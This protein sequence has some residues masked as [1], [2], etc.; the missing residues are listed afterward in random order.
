MVDNLHRNHRRRMKERLRRQG[1]DSFAP[2]EQVELLLYY[3]IPRGDVNP[4]AHRLIDTFG[5]LA[6]ICQARWED[7]TAVQGV[8][9]HTA[10]FFQTLPQAARVYWES[11]ATPVDGY[12]TAQKIGTYL[13][14][15]Y[16]GITKETV[17]LL[18]FGGRM[19]L[20]GCETLC[21]GSLTAVT[22]NIRTILERAIVVGAARVVLAH[23][24]PD[25]LAIPS[26]DDLCITQNLAA[27]LELAGIPLVEHF[28]IAGDRWT[29]ILARENR[30]GRLAQLEHYDAKTFYGDP[31]APDIYTSR[32]SED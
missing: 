2:H 27:A 25:G 23:N 13:L 8:S 30:A 31:S 9:E 24:H 32:P 15:Q 7:L 5:S 11:A 3:C 12:D 20:L 4:L 14:R 19:N 26:G 10:L 22:P 21:T 28:V 29:A 16:L 1:L 18:L 17:L 6:G